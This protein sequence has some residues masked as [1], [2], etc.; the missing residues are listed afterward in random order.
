MKESEGLYRSF[1]FIRQALLGIAALFAGLLVFG[2]FFFMRHVDA[3][4]AQAAAERELQGGTLHFGERV[5]KKAKVYERRPT[6]YFRGSD[7]ILFATNDRLLFIGT[8]PSDKLESADAPPVM[9]TQEYP[10]DTL[11]KVEHQRLFFLTAHGAVVQR[12]GYPTGQFGAN[13]GDEKSLDELID[14]VTRIHA[15]QRADAAKEREL[16]RAVAEMIRQPLY[17]TV[18]RGDAVSSIAKKFGATDDQLRSWNKL[19]S[20]RVKIGEKLLVKPAGK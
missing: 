2:Y 17:Y 18:K 16:R 6:D 15:K 12:P 5:E 10:N 9:I 4:K 19:T 11:L 14:Y 20:D 3:P 8:A 7:G 13:R 1:N